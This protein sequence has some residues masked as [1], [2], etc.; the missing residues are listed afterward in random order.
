MSV[1]LREQGEQL[2]KERI[3]GTRKG[4]DDPQYLHS[5]RVAKT[6]EEFGYDEE[7]ILAGLLHDIIEDSDMTW[8]E[9]RDAGY[10]DRTLEMVDLCTHKEDIPNGDARWVEMVGRLAVAR[11]PEAWAV[12]IADLSDNM[13]DAGT[14]PEDRMWFMREVKAPMLL[15]VSYDVVHETPIWQSLKELTESYLKD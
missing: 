13:K 15:N 11:D 10:S 9:L 6:L 7:V 12:K 4:S 14:M 1:S 3:L 2:V 5:I 8:D